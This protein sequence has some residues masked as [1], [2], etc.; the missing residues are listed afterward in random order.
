[1]AIRF[2]SFGAGGGVRVEDAETPPALPGGGRC[3]WV[4]LDQATDEQLLWLQTT[5]GFHPLTIED[6]RVFN[7]RAKVEEYDGYL[8]ITYAIPRLNTTDE[9]I[10]ADELHAFLGRNYLV[11]IHEIPLAG[12]DTVRQ[13]ILANH[14]SGPELTPD[15]LYYLISD[16]LVDTYFPL[17]DRLEEDI[18]SVEDDVVTQPDRAT[19]TRIFLLKQHL[20][21]MRKTAGPKREVFNALA[22]TRYALIS[23]RTRYYFR[24][25]YDHLVRVYEVIETSRELLSN[26]LDAYLSVVSNRLNDV[27]K[28]LTLIATIFMP[29]SF[30]AG[31]GGINFTD[32]PFSNTRAFVLFWLVIIVSMIC[33]LIYFRRKDWI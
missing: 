6:V 27:M 25:I 26:A 32:M 10:D 9:V 31:V 11:T 28:R 17:V 33:M 15:F 8:F 16:I 13:R 7:Q 30:V 2:I 20:I 1:M 19:L 21:Y 14:A 18:D 22:G 5:F 4:D 3:L 24:D 12:I 29:L 23:D